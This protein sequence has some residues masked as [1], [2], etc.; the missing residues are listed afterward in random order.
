MTALPSASECSFSGPTAAPQAALAK[1]ILMNWTRAGI[2]AFV[3]LCVFV[4]WPKGQDAAPPRPLLIKAALKDANDP[5]V[6]LGDSIVAQAT[7]PRTICNRPLINA[8]IIGSTTKSGLD[9]MLIK[10][11][12]SNKQPAM[13]VV[14]LGIND[15]GNSFSVQDY[16]ANYLA[17]LNGLKVRSSRLAVLSITPVEKGAAQNQAIENYNA[18][19][20]MIAQQAGAGLIAVPPLP[21][22]PTVDGIHL[23][24]DGYAVWT[25]ALLGGIEAVLCKTS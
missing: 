10:A 19:L 7:L 15:A 2:V 3:A 21:A 12:G 22:K 17:L 4:A 14:S 25:K 13:I 8:G 18:A 24:N 5:V 1:E 6:V 16:S 9:A 23:N 11:L 20:P